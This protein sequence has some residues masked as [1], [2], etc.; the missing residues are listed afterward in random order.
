MGDKSEKHTHSKAINYADNA[1]I[2]A[3]P[4]N[5]RISRQ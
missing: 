4:T 5:A 1:C 2:D 3:L